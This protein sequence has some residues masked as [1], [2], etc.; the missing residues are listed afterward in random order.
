MAFWETEFP[1]AMDFNVTGGDGFSTTVNKGFGGGEGRNRNWTKSLSIFNVAFKAKDIDYIEKVRNFFLNVGGQWDG[2]RFWWPLD[3]KLENQIIATA[4]GV[5]NPTFQLVKTYTA[6]DR[7]Y[8]RTV[9]KPIMSDVKDFEGNAMTDTIILRDNGVTKTLSTDY[10]V[11]S[12]TGEIACHFTPLAGH[13][14][15]VDGQFHIPVRFNVD[16]MSAAQIIESDVYGGNPLTSWTG[17]A[18]LEIRP[19]IDTELES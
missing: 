15:T 1:R 16:D 10:D 11:D 4:T 8:V 14:I 6:S 9:T 18:L 5:A 2:F 13:L 3:Y 7:T 17:I 19:A 12:T